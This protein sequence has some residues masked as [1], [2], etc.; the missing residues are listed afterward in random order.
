[1]RIK[2]SNVAAANFNFQ[3]SF[4][5]SLSSRKIQQKFLIVRAE[6]KESKNLF[7]VIRAGEKESPLITYRTVSSSSSQR[8]TRKREKEERKRWR[9]HLKH[10]YYV[11]KKCHLTIL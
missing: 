7:S 10:Q 1:M 2:G 5:P 3:A 9:H 6:E 8:K 4:R 11:C